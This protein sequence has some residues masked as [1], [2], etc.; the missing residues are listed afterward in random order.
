MDGEILD[1]GLKGALVF[2]GTQGYCADQYYS[3][4]VKLPN[5]NQGAS[6]LF[7][8]KEGKLHAA[9]GRIVQSRRDIK[10]AS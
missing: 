8:C 3:A 4:N 2:T 10:I 6:P 9:I 7:P 1:S 5:E